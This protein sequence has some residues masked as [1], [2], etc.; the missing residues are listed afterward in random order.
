MFDS[1]QPLWT[2]AR[3]SPLSILQARILEWVATS[4]SRRSSQPRA[5]AQ[6]LLYLLHRQAD[7]LPPAPPA[8]PSNVSVGIIAVH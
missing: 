8:K 4:S 6:R 3:Q 5:R 2:V 7:S 1:L